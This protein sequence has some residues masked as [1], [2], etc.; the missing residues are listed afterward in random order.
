[1]PPKKKVEAPVGEKSEGKR[2]A[3]EE[4]GEGEEEKG[5][6]ENE[7]ATSKGVFVRESGEALE[8]NLSR[9]YPDKEKM[10]AL[11]IVCLSFSIFP[12]LSFLL[13]LYSSLSFLPS[14]ISSF[15]LYMFVFLI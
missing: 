11:I 3:T 13:C 9:S 4:K 15:F 7:K 6:E 14:D 5:K 12:S 2:E 10:E 1:M 8:F